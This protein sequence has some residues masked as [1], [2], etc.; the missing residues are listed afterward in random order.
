MHFVFLLLAAAVPAAQP[1]GPSAGFERRIANVIAR[2]PGTVSL[3]AK[4]LDTGRSY[5][6]RADD[7]VRTA[8]TIKLPIMV[9]VFGEAEAGRVH[10]TDETT[11]REEDKISGSGIL[12]EFS[13]GD[14]IP[15]VDLVHL[16]IVVSDNTATNLVLDRVP[17]DT[18]NRYMDQ[19]G[20]PDTRCLRK[21][22]GDR[23][24]LKAA[25]GYS[26]AGRLERNKRYGIGVSTPRE[27]VSLLERIERGQAVSPAASK[28]MIAI[29]KRQHYTEGIGR[30]LGDTPVASKSGALDALRS[31]VGI[32]YSKHGRIA[33]AIT[34][35]GMKRV[36]WSPDNPGHLTISAIAGILIEGLAS[37]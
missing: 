33:M 20:L 34:V 9:A 19:Y 12:R 1:A 16:M 11:L 32:V 29:L 21:I 2:A 30:R 36:D 14:R 22:L 24:Q 3:F 23:N 26:E 18:V 13:P 4:N 27:M 10:W 25:N 6:V 15:L 8:S 28:E 7:K 5:G 37:P 35:D 31:D 17:A